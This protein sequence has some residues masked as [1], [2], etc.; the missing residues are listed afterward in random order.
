MEI[1]VTLTVSVITFIFLW[2]TVGYAY[3]MARLGSKHGS[4]IEEKSDDSVM[5]GFSIILPVYNEVDALHRR[6]ENL[7]NLHY[8]KDL[9]EIIIVESGS[10]DGTTD[11]VKDLIRNG[12]GE[13]PIIKAVFQAER[14]GKTSAIVEGKKSAA[15]DYI[16]ITDGNSRFD[17]NVLIEMAGQLR[18]PNV[19]AVGGRFKIGNLG[20]AVPGAGFFWDMEFAMR[21]GEAIFDSACLIHG[22]ISGWR[23]KEFEPDPRMISEDLDAAITFRKRGKKIAYAPRAIVYEDAPT[24]ARDQVIQRRK[25]ALGTLMEIKKHARYLLL[26]RD[27]YTAV[28]FPSHRTLPMLT[29]FM[30][31]LIFVLYILISNPIFIIGH[32]IITIIAGLLLFLGLSH[33]IH[34]LKSIFD[35]DEIDKSEMHPLRVLWFFILNEWI[36]LLGW[37][38]FIFGKHSVLWEKAQT[39]R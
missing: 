1:L 26:P 5:I 3:L 12:D 18:K 9:F 19:G 2:S 23:K 16:I 6:I 8:P 29:P 31:L 15:F 4:R 10:T 20:K 38:D 36:I 24:E 25:T 28:I 37:K 21:Y 33:E 13:H 17:N 7:R 34:Q 27:R 39:N 35:P 30:L 22:E 32:L 14:R 11:L